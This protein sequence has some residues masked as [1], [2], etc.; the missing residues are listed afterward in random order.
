MCMCQAIEEWVINN[1]RVTADKNNKV[2]AMVGDHKEMHLVHYS[3]FTTASA[4][5][6]FSA[7]NPACSFKETT[8]RAKL[9]KLYWLKV[10]QCSNNLCIR[11]ANMRE[12]LEKLKAL[13]LANRVNESQIVDA[14]TYE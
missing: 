2:C 10:P 13:Q 5:N 1:S 12:V 3:E 9:R 4:W 6:M 8:F 14:N 11:C 7:D